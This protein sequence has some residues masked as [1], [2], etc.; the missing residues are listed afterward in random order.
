MYKTEIF[1]LTK[2]VKVKV[3]DYMYIHVVFFKEKDIS[4]LAIIHHN[5]ICKQKIN[6]DCTSSGF[7]IKKY[8]YS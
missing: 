7:P 2:I 4:F 6:H 8:D 3:F 1:G 5:S